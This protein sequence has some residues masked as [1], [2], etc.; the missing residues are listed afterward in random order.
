M[1]SEYI[2][3]ACTECGSYNYITKKNKQNV[4]GKLKLKKYCKRERR[5]TVHEE[6]R[7]RD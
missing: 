2:W 7:L 4:K 5:H 6:T 1:P 3:L